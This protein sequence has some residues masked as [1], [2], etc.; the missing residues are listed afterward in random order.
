MGAAA[1]HDGWVKQLVV[2]ALA[3]AVL[4]G[5]PASTA[6]AQARTPTTI[7]V[8]TGDDFYVPPVPLP[9][10][11]P[12]A[13]IWAETIA[14]P[15]G[16]RA[17]RVLSH[18]KSIARQDAA[19]SGVVV[20][21]DGPAPKRGRPI[22]SWAHGTTGLADL[23]A[24]SKASDAAFRIPFV[25]ELLA[26]G[27]V[28]AATDYQGLG[29]PGVHPY[30]VGESEGRAVL[31]TAR[32]ARKLA[33]GAGKRVL[34]AGHSQGGHAALFASEIASRYAP[35]LEVVGTAAGAPVTDVRQFLDLAALSP[36]SAGFLVM[37][38][39]GY[40]AA[41]PELARAPLFTE[42]AAS[43]ASIAVNRCAA[44]VILTF[45]GDAPGSLFTSDPNQV[46]M[47]REKLY[48][49]APGNRRSAAP[50]LVW[51][52]NTDVLTP[53]TLV[54]PY[55]QKACAKK[56]IV[57]YREYQGADHGSVMIAAKDD[58]LSF[59]AARLAGDPPQSSCR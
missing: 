3:I 57:E 8:P 25:N 59:F 11:K 21:P 54:F 42:S 1:C 31:D 17:W 28:V 23:C 15:L 6:R 32:V 53:S 18:T 13:L 49:N 24:P 47:W 19:L 30:L 34:I 51:Q 33:A 41:Y 40:S 43:R 45:A 26:A 12:G 56:S 38:A 39:Q 55:V 22:V 50:I 44:E 36:S 46:A 29:T 48:E 10:G 5:I 14:A 58:V 35:E 2:V 27:Y 9:S 37:G 7:V 52:G 20:T 16:A 4:V